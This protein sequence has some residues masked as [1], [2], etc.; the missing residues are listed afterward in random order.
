MYTVKDIYDKIEELAPFC[1]QEGYDNSGLC[2]GNMSRPADRILISLDC[3]K[4]VALEAAEKGY[5]LIVTHHPVIFRGIK[6]LDP[7]SVVGILAANGI[8]VISAHTNFDSAVM[9][10]VL[11]EKLGLVPTGCIT[12]E[13]GAETGC[14]CEHEGITAEELAEVC[15][16][17]L[18]TPAVRYDKANSGLLKRIA[19]CSGSGG[20][21]LSEVLAKGCDGYITGDVKHDVFID[22]YNAGLTVFDAGHFYTEDIFCGYI[23]DM[24]NNNFPQAETAIAESSR[25][26][27][28]WYI[29]GN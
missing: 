4:D 23:L 26:V 16:K 9:N 13:H 20:S 6:Q 11:C 5:Q 1:L 22:A 29:G 18:G 21:F 10:K 17:K 19:V 3:T 24:L 25:D 27:V 2:V 28:E 14:I 8:S 12:E 15:R 7:D